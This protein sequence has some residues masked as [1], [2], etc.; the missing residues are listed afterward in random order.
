MSQCLSRW[1]GEGVVR[2]CRLVRVRFGLGVWAASTSA[3]FA[4]LLCGGLSVHAFTVFRFISI[5]SYS[6]YSHT[7]STSPADMFSN[8]AV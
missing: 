8:I 4:Q 2:P 6:Y 1:D 5:S 3:V 7:D